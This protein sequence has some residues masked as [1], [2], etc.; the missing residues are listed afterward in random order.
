MK[1][2]VISLM[3]GNCIHKMFS[4]PDNSVDLVLADPPYGTTACKWDA[5][6][7]FSLMW[8]QLRRI[9]KRNSVI[10]L[11][12]TQPFSS[13]LVMS[14]PKM[15]KYDWIW[16]KSKGS[17]FV[18]APNMPLKIYETISVFSSGSISHKSQVSVA[19]R[20][21]Y[22]PQGTVEGRTTVKQNENSSDLKY[23]RGSQTNHTTGYKC[24]RENY[25][26]TILKFKSELGLH[27]TQKPVD[28]LEY[29]IKTYTSEGDTV[30]D[31]TM[32]SGST[33]V[34]AK[35]TGRS[36]TGIELSAKYFEIA[37]NRIGS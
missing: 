16:V 12:G 5:I 32:G 20:M 29:L 28:L 9:T 10:C 25:P 3:Q 26:S 22:N 34:A 36:F 17:N 27:P 15:Y 13:A 6:I 4:I 7:P 37:K 24:K 11:F 30:L 14:N 1:P 18:H 23:H 35:N 31:F 8:V 2:P 33:G 19:D 21:T